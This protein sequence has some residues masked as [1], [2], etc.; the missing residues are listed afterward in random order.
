M[1]TPKLQ[2][3][4]LTGE[5]FQLSAGEFTIEGFTDKSGIQWFSAKIVCE[6]LGLTNVSK[7]VSALPYRHK[8]T[9]TI[10][11]SGRPVSRL[12][13]TEP[14]LYRLI[15]RSHKENAER[16]QDWI[17]DQ[18]LP[19]IRIKGGYISPDAS[20]VQLE[21][22]KEDIAQKER[23]IASKDRKIGYLERVVRG[24]EIMAEGKGVGGFMDNSISDGDNW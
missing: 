23:L 11:D 1:P 17:F 8:A 18:V 21:Y 13:I 9:I 12:M 2:V 14:G 7:S 4:D 24:H 15:A 6:N 16:F 5:T 19:S 20:A 3:I 10:S 22:L